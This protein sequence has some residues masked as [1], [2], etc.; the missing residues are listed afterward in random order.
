[1]IREPPGSH[2]LDVGPARLTGHAVTWGC[3]YSAVM[4]AGRLAGSRASS[5]R[6]PGRPREARVDAAALAAARELLCEVGYAATTID[7]IARRAQV[8]RTAL[9]RRWPS[10][11][12]LVHE[13]VFAPADPRLHVT[14]TGDLAADLQA[15][16]YGW[17]ALLERPEIL[18]AMPG[19]M[20]DAV[21]DARLREAF[22]AG[23]EAAVREELTGIL[24]DA[25]ARGQAQGGVSAETILHLLAGTILLRATAWGPDSLAGLARE[26]TLILHRSCLR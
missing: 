14:S 3:S 22:R 25:A 7:T 19:L 20:A 6:E 21:A 12:L 15:L 4:S 18:A 26:L 2:D 17:V 16:V 9:Y 11:A 24:S 8:S 23:L 1:M 13:A 5:G 10:K